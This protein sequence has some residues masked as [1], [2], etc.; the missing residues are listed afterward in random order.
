[1]NLGRDTMLTTRMQ[2]RT[3]DGIEDLISEGKVSWRTNDGK[4]K[5]DPPYQPLAEL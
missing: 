1:M 2:I 3:F 4:N 5:M